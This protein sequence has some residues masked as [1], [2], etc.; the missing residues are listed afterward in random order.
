MQPFEIL[1][2]IIAI[3]AGTFLVGYLA[4]KVFGLINSWINR[5]KTGISEDK[6]REIVDFMNNTEHRLRS[7][8]QIIVDQD[9]LDEKKLTQLPDFESEDEKKSRLSNRLK[10]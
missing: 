3:V 5:K 10:S 4:S 8:E 6:A 2:P 1:I 9:F 7:L